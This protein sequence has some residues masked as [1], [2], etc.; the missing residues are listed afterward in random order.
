MLATNTGIESIIEHTQ[1]T[2]LRSIAQRFFGLSCQFY[3][4]EI[5]P[6]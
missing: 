3:S 1:D 2:D 4:T 5:T 6:K